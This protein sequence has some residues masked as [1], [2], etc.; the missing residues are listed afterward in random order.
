[1]FVNF[2]LK[3]FK[4]IVGKADENIVRHFARVCWLTSQHSEYIF[5]RRMLVTVTI[6]DKLLYK[7]VFNA[8]FTEDSNFSSLFLEKITDTELYW[9]K[10]FEESQATL[11]GQLWNY[12]RS[13]GPWTYFTGVLILVFLTHFCGNFVTVGTL[14]PQILSN[15]RTIVK[16]TN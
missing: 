14:V 16:V 3:S 7:K 8:F 1:M 4:I 12:V 5:Q 6:E 15:C 11:D 10:C 9:N 13:F 2:H